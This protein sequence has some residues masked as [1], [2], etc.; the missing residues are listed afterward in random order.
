MPV[1]CAVTQYRRPFVQ[2]R[3]WL[4]NMICFSS[5]R[6]TT[7]LVFS[8]FDVPFFLCVGPK[9][10][11]SLQDT[12]EDETSL[13]NRKIKPA[14]NT[15]GNTH[16]CTL[17]TSASCFYCETKRRVTQSRPPQV[18]QRYFI[19]NVWSLNWVL[20]KYCTEPKK[21]GSKDDLK[22]KTTQ[23]QTASDTEN[24]SIRWSHTSNV[25]KYTL[26]L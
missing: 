5:A 13:E 3:L 16:S 20:R 22:K 21:K 10:S 7:E 24:I 9:A 11:R 18:T 23:K 17:Y 14:S 19:T 25:N 2:D 12:K 15:S 4:C 26:F 1:N 6:F 8:M